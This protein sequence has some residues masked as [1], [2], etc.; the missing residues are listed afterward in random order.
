MN[1]ACLE[2]MRISP[3]QCLQVVCCFQWAVAGSYCVPNLL[4]R[5]SQD[6]RGLDGT[7]RSRTQVRRK[8]LSSPPSLVEPVSTT[9]LLMFPRCFFPTN[10]RNTCLVCVRASS[11]PAHASFSPPPA[12]AAA[13]CLFTTFLF[14]EHY[15]IY[16]YCCLGVCLS[17]R[18][19]VCPQALSV[20]GYSLTPFLAAAPLCLFSWPVRSCGLATA[21]LVAAIFVLRSAWPRLQEHMP[22]KSMVLL[23]TAV[24]TY[25]VLW[26][27][28][29]VFV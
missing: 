14:V 9:A 6:V 16:K 7:H 26:F 29:L 18:L 27:L 5:A 17:V 15:C 22:E 11:F 12:S 23:L 19:P 25:H 4:D 3:Q 1:F 28:L 8:N 13:A 21:S 2:S 10:L 24:A 20:Y